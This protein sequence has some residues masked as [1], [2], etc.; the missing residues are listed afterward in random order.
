M[1]TM[2]TEAGGTWME[3][4]DAPLASSR[5][6][7]TAPDEAGGT[8]ME[9]SDEAGPGMAGEVGLSDEG[10]RT[11]GEADLTDEGHQALEDVPRPEDALGDVPPGA[12][13]Y[14]ETAP[15]D[16]TV[17]V[18]VA[19]DEARRSLSD[20]PAAELHDLLGQQGETEGDREPGS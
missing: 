20:D 18:G 12:T 14:R 15:L 7:D 10:D 19:A 3:E 17:G 4:P 16:E 5:P 11:G 2:N 8:W 13:S 6:S 1:R 9:R